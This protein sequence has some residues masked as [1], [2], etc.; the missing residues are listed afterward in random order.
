M[1]TRLGQVSITA[2]LATLVL[3]FG[4]RGEQILTQPLVILLLVV[5]ILLQVD[6]NAGLAYWLNKRLVVAMA[7]ALFGLNP[8]ATVVGVLVEV[9]VMLSVVRIVLAARRGYGETCAGAAGRG[10]SMRPATGA[11]R[12][13]ERRELVAR[14]FRLEWLTIG[15]MSVE[16]VIATVSG[17]AAH[18]ISLLAFGIDSVIELLSAFVLVWRH[19]VELRH[20]EEFSEAAERLASRIGGAL[21]LA[22]AAYVVAS[23]GWSL[24][25]RQGEEFSLPG[26]IVAALAVPMMYGLATAKLRLAGRLGS[27]ALRADAVESI[28]CGYLSAIVVVGLLAQWLFGAWWIDGVTALALVYFLVREGL[29]TWRDEEC[30]D[31]EAP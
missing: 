5:R 4:F 31:A 13:V 3:H 6:L 2:V 26:L 9:P 15:W 19:S 21:L 29:E 23:A 14:A 7:I 18:S 17:L 28:A 1:L 20:G 24:W 8:G 25:Q 11:E 30:C 12:G 27:H 10:E 16:A 22:L